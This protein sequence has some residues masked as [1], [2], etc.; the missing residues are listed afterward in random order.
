MNLVHYLN[1]KMKVEDSHARFAQVKQLQEEREQIPVAD[2]LV[3]SLDTVLHFT[4]YCG[5]HMCVR[6]YNLIRHVSSW[7]VFY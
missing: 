1:I 6:E 3:S 2:A 4:V 5:L 7:G